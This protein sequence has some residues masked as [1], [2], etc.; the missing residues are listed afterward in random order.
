MSISLHI[1]SLDR[2]SPEDQQR[3]IVELFNRL[4]SYLN[5]QVTV[6]VRDNLKK[7][8]PKF[9][10]GDLLFDLAEA[11]GSLQIYEWNGV[12]LVPITV[13]SLVGGITYDDIDGTLDLIAKGSGSG[14]DPTLFL[15]SDGAGGWELADPNDYVDSREPLSNGSLPNPEILF[16]GIT[17]DVVMHEV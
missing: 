13:A 10:Q 12:E 5:G 15:K 3:Q 6:Y 4:E 9:K 16:D 11:P 17:G 2:L 8:F 7:P 1:G 14:T